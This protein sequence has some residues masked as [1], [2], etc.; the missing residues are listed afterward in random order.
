VA[1]STVICIEFLPD[2]APQK[3]FKSANAALSYS[4]NKNG[5][6]LWTTVYAAFQSVI[7]AE[8]E[9]NVDSGSSMVG[10]VWL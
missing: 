4:K 3:L 5:M 7:V 10:C 8:C 1:K 9:L 2:V 6:F